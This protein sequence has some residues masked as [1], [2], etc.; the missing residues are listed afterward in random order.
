MIRPRGTPGNR[1]AAWLMAALAALPCAG[2][3]MGAA[4]FEA[5]IRPL[6]VRHC[7]GCHNETNR[8]SGL[9]LASRAA[10]A[11]GGNRGPG[12]DW[13]VKAVKHEDGLKMPPGRQLP[14]DDVA[15]LERWV[16]AG[17]LWPKLG[18]ESG[19]ESGPAS[20]SAGRASAKR[21]NHWTFQTPVRPNEPNPANARWARTAID[22]F[23]LA[24]LEKEQLPPSPEAGKLTLL[25]RVHLDHTG[26]P[27][28]PAEIDHF[29]NDPAPDAYEKAVDRLLASPHY[30]ERQAR[31][32]L[33][34]A[35]YADSDGGSR[36]EP[37]HIWKYREW[38]IEALNRDLPF[39]RFVIEQLAGDLLPGATPEQ[40]IATG[41]H[42]NS[43]LQ[44]EAGT[45][46]EQYRVEAVADR[47][48]ATGTT[49]L[50]LSTGCARCHD[51]KY[52][53]ISQKEY[54]QLFAFF[55][56]L[57]E[58]GPE[59][60]PFSAT[61]DLNV[62]HAPLLALGPPADVAKWQALQA[63]LLALYQER[64]AYR[65]GE[66]DEL[67]KGDAGEKIR[68]ETI[69]ALKK[70]L[71]TN[72]TFAM[73]MRERRQPRPAH[74]LLG[75]DYLRK[76]IAVEPGVPAAFP[77]AAGTVRN[78]LDLAR[79]ITS[80]KNPLF[81]RVAV[82]RQWQRFFGTGLVETENDFGTQG[83]APSHP[84][85]LDWLATE[86]IR[87]GWSQK[88]LQRLI[89]TSAAYRQE[90]RQRAD[91][92]QRDPNNR[93]LGRQTRLRLDA[94]IVRDNALA[95][96]GLLQ[97]K[98]GGPSVYPPQPEGVMETGQVKQLW[99]TSQGEDRYRRGLYTFHYRI[100]PN[101]SMKVFD[102]ANGL[103]PCTRRPRT[104]TPLQS[105]T[106]LNDPNFHEMAQALARR[107]AAAADPLAEAY[108]LT[109]GRLPTARERERL[110]RLHAV[111]RDA[112]ATKPEEAEA[113]AGKGA[114]PELAAWTTVA[115]VL[116]NTDEFITRE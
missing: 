90:A 12:F 60:P 48:D 36:D 9:S 44:I 46:R 24:R 76:G 33:D 68:T 81:A 38:V 104:N 3:E 11:A 88:Q 27:P 28:T 19:P 64:F 22:R 96:S 70:Q 17:G 109:A 29:L 16:A 57:D 40:M 115:R 67:P 69:N 15:K 72:L 66:S 83:A 61:N 78:R 89:V 74:V 45:D 54:Y 20:G 53:P 86:F 95:A 113:L 112:F 2:Q 4:S 97:A 82:N 32:W 98:L 26:L 77:P 52:D 107:V 23:V 47:V 42:R 6:L 75:G 50:G 111:E 43:L 56:N 58:Y 21:R 30:G 73:V 105:L 31:H 39:D 114:G 116:L 106:L 80:E 1:C 102:G 7:Q 84:E 25:R 94:E 63:Q 35:R 62:T 8:S 14:P 10:L 55:N 110:R 93:L 103:T 51:H 59:L 41:F 18:P 101:P 85:L 92:A 13:I 5:E 37:R 79:W 49:L 100:T 34:Q 108:R 99:R 65:G 87:L 91:L 71:P